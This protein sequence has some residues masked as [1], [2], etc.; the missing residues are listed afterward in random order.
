M[1][2]EEKFTIIIT[3][4]G[5]IF[6]FSSIWCKNWMILRTLITGILLVAWGSAIH[7]VKKGKR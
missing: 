2:F 4:I 1:K 6:I 7:M 5:I 3:F